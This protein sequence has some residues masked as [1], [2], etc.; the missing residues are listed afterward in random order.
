MITKINDTAACTINAAYGVAYLGCTRPSHAGIYESSPATNGIRAEPPSHAEPI[1][2]IDRL[3]KNANGATIHA[4]PTRSAMW[5]TDCTIPCNTLMLPFSTEINK[6]SV[7]PTYSS[8]ERT[9][10]HAT[11]PGRVFR[12]FSI[13]SPMIE[14]S[15]SPTNPKQ[16]TPNEL[17]KN[18]GF[19]GIWKSAQVIVVPNFMHT[20]TPSPIN[21]NA[22]I[23]VPMAPR[24][25]NHFPTLMPKT[26]KTTRI[27]S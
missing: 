10:P 23:N 26:F 1:P 27:V 11:A 3:N 25:F 5:L 13:S 18:L 12:G 21:R 16:I 17:S 6:V 8:P 22:A 19:A 24:L 2:A 7:A 9:P 20:T 14:A 4:T 15:S